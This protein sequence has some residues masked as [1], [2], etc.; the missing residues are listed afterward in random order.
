MHNLTSLIT[1][2]MPGRVELR[3]NWKSA[4]NE[5][6]YNTD[7]HPVYSTSSKPSRGTSPSQVFRRLHVCR[8]VDSQ[9]GDRSFIVTGPRL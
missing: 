1:E 6:Y 7:L 9:I 8:P 5:V 3:S 4:T 2:N